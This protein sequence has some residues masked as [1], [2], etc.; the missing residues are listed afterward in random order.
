LPREHAF[1]A[2]DAVECD[3]IEP[4]D[5]LRRALLVVSPA[6]DRVCVAKLMQR[7]VAGLDTVADPASAFPF[8]RRRTSLQHLREGGVASD[9]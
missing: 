9:G 1:A 3:T 8:A 2:K 7:F 6:F 5:Q 4:A